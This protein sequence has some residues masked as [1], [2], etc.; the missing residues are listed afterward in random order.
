[1]PTHPDTIAT[2][3]LLERGLALRRAERRASL[4]AAATPPRSVWADLPAPVTTA[5]RSGLARVLRSLP[6]VLRPVP[7]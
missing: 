7:A 2:V 1:M 6:W 4:L 3:V 5:R